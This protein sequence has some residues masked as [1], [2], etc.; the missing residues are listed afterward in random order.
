MRHLRRRGFLRAFGYD[1]Y[2]RSFSDTSVLSA[3]YDC[4]ISQD[5]LEHVPAPLDFLNALHRLTNPGGVIAIGTPNAEAIRLE[6]GERHLH[7]LHQPYHRHVF[8]ERALLDAGRQRGW[9]LEQLYRTQYANTPVPFLN[10]RF[11]LYYLRLC[12]DCVDALMEPPAAAPLLARLPVTLFW[13]LFGFFFA[14]ATDIMAVF[15]R[16][17]AERALG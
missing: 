7:A 13:G 10:S 11:Y 15:R 3:R 2:S 1:E 17:G 12:G 8:S 6:A 4:V 9:N 5:V 16:D 14:E